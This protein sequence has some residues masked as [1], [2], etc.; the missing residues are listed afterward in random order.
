MDKR[1]K[2]TEEQLIKWVSDGLSFRDMKKECGYSISSISGFFDEYGIEK[3][4]PGR[5]KGFKVSSE[6]REKLR[7]RM[8]ELRDMEGV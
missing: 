2:P 4:K 7:E 6:T 8:S 3:P 1:F 5:K